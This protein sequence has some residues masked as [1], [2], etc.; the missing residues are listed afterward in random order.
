MKVLVTG[1][2]GYIGTELIQV[3]NADEGISEIVLYD[4]MSTGNYN[5]F[6]GRDKLDKNKVKFVE[7]DILDSR[8]LIKALK[9][10]KVVY[11]IAAKVTTPYANNDPHFFEQVNHWGTAELVYA[12]EESDV[13]KLIFTSSASVFGSST[14]FINEDSAINPRTFYGISKMRG[15]EHVARL[16]DKKKAYI[17]RCGN[18]Y[19]YSKSMRFDAVINKFMFDA[20]YK[21]RISI[22]GSGLQSRGFIHIDVLTSYLHQIGSNDVPTGTYNLVDKNIKILD[23]VDVLKQE[24]Y[25]ELEFIFVNQHL[26]LRDLKIAPESALFDH[27]NKCKSKQLGEELFEF[28][29][30]FSF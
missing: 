30:K 23:I 7:G 17:L 3:L 15:E 19:G 2:A 28:K 18:V 25:P 10:V 9:G 5:L 11:H 29:R 4:N 8:N 14:G 6:I 21:G 12:I 16:F 24:I 26:K 1:G 13:E 27:I 20:N 22:H